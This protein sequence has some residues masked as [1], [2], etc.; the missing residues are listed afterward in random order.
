MGV[1]EVSHVSDTKGMVMMTLQEFCEINGRNKLKDGGY[2]EMEVH[3][4]QGDLM[5]SW[6]E[7]DPKYCAEVIRIQPLSD[8]L[9]KVVI[10]YKGE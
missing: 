2:D 4:S 1:E 7:Y 9:V 3:N 5:T 10:K 8:T 6:V